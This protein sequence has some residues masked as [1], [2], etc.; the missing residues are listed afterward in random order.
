MTD[1]SVEV[2]DC[3]IIVR[4]SHTGHCVMY[5]RAPDGPMLIALDQLRDDPDRE[6]AKFLVQ[7][8]K[9]AYAKAMAFGWI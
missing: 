8:W 5:R 6:K 7:A 4:S 3:D 1:L 9:A 2:R